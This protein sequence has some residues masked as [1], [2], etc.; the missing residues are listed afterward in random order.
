MGKEEFELSVFSD[1]MI[2][3]IKDLMIPPKSS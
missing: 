1:D 2:L 3:Y